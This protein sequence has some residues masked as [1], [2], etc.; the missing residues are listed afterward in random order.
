VAGLE[1]FKAMAN[2]LNIFSLSSFA[3]I[4]CIGVGD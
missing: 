3:K 1:L 4:F 2:E